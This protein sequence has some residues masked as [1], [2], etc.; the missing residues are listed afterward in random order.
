MSF[1]RRLRYIFYILLSLFC[2]LLFL[3]TG[4][5]LLWSAPKYPITLLDSGWMVTDNETV[6]TDVHINEIATQTIDRD[7]VLILT[8]VL[9]EEVPSACLEVETVRAALDVFVD[10]ERIYSYGDTTSKR[11]IYNNVHDIRL[12]EGY[13]EKSLTLLI[14]T[15]T[16][17]AFSGLAPIY[18]GNRMDML[19]F[20]LNRHLRPLFYGTFLLIYGLFLFILAIFMFNALSKD[21]RIMFSAALVIIFGL[22]ALTYN[23]IF[24]VVF[25]EAVNVIVENAVLFLI[26]AAIAAFLATIRGGMVRRIF[27]WMA[28]FNLLFAVTLIALIVSGISQTNQLLPFYHM[29][30]LIEG[31]LCMVLLWI[32]ITSGRGSRPGRGDP[33]GKK[34]F[35]RQADRVLFA[36]VIAIIIGGMADTIDYNIR[37]MRDNLNVQTAGIDLT[38]LGVLIFAG[39]LLLN[40]FFY[41]VEH[42]NEIVTNRTLSDIAFTDPLT[43]LANRTRCEQVMQR[44]EEEHEDFSVLSFDIQ[45]LKRTNDA[46]GH[47][48]GDRLLKGFADILREVF[49]ES[50]LIGRIGGDEFVVVMRNTPKSVCAQK[51][52]QLRQVMSRYNRTERTFRYDAACGYAHKSERIGATAHDIY[53]IADE[54]MYTQKRHLHEQDEEEVA[55]A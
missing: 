40:Y 8:H 44:L 33:F 36:G 1:F 31:I 3:P 15:N 20:W 5:T 22:Y 26:P 13:G 12:P 34:T 19:H 27:T 35:M 51:E 14:R 18:V 30:L 39:C 29:L 7:D 2:V 37:Q 55:R 10:E 43:G 28:A 16:N 4:T 48:E 21:L 32:D 38:L 50:D 49:R 9:P 6:R 17:N 24:D 52:L 47:A 53:Q 54:R 42:A 25:N 11:L 45:N 41:T 23:R 46:Y